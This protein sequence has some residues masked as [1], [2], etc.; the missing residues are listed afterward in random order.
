VLQTTYPLGDEVAIKL[1]TARWY[2]PSGRSVQRPRPDVEGAL[3]NRPPSLSPRIFHS[4]AGRPIP[5]ASGILPDLTIRGLP[6]SDAER[7]LLAALGEDI[8][9]FRSVLS[10]YAGEIRTAVTPR[11]AAFRVTQ[12]MRDR[13]FERLQQVGLELPRTTY[14]T[15]STY[16]D[17]QLGYEITRTVFGP[18]AEAKRRALSDRQMQAA[19][20][21]LR[22]SRTQDGVFAVAV[23]ERARGMTR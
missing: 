15:A 18:D 23:A 6:R 5:D 9:S 10:D 4:D 16:V 7:A 20:R 8:A 17:E 22:L 14:D 21:L 13:L 19:A 3:G 12:E 2:T 1:T 11:S